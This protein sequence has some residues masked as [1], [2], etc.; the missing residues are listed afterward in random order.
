MEAPIPKQIQTLIQVYD[1]IFQEPKQLPPQRAMDHH[2]PLIPG[3]TPVNVKPY[4]YSPSQ[5]DETKPAAGD[6]EKWHNLAQCE[7]VCVTCAAGQEEGRILAFLC[8][9]SL[10]QCVDGQKQVSYA[11]RR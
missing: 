2:I 6:V 1:P 11:H 8:R 7:S 3:A 5:K 10:G 9:L 4:R